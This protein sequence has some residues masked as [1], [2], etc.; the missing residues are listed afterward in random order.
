MSGS[1]RDQVQLVRD[2][3]VGRPPAGTSHRLHQ[4]LW[5]SSYTYFGG[6]KAFKVLS[7]RMDQT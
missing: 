4:P 6:P 7:T 1:P 2:D 3:E 5:I